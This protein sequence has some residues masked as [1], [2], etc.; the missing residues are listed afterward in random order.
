M[1]TAQITTAILLALVFLPLGLAKTA[2][3][4]AMSQAAAHLGMAPGFYRVV[5][6]LEVAG[7]RVRRHGS[8][9]WP[10]D[11]GAGALTPR[12]MPVGLDGPMPVHI[13]LV[14]MERCPPSPDRVP[15][16]LGGGF[17]QSPPL[18]VTCGARGRRI[19]VALA[20]TASWLPMPRVRR[21]RSAG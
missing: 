5:G 21:L 10:G 11:A 8:C 19:D 18:T 12:G 13:A 2:A 1:R 7:V 6:T 14:C 4:P 3:V 16:G 17:A 15:L 20:T 9:P